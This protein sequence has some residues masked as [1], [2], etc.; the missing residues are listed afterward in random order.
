MTRTHPLNSTRRLSAAL[1]FV[2]IAAWAALGGIAAAQTTAQLPGI[3][4]TGTG[5][6]HGE[7]DQATLD[8]GVTAVAS[9]VREAMAEVDT[10]MVAVRDAVVAAGVDP[11]DVRTTGF[12]VWREQPMDR[13]GNPGAE[14]FHVR[15]AYQVAVRDIGS[16]GEVLAAAV[17]AGANDIGGIQFSVSDPSALASA[18]RELAM[19]D[20]RAK[21]TELA[22][23]GGV[24]LSAPVLISEPTVGG[25]APQQARVAFDAGFGGAS[26]ETGQLAVTVQVQVTFGIE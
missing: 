10:V 25:F 2:A 16:L 20:A 3:Q 14:R 26:I 17:A 24:T 23:L 22:S 12:S 19:E 15:H 13:D 4:V 21:A 5:V 18:A 6:V 8:L 1:V 7:P 11:L 9:D